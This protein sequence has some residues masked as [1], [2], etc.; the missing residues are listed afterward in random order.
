[1]KLRVDLSGPKGVRERYKGYLMRSRAEVVVAKRLD[2]E[3]VEWKYE[4]RVVNVG[5]WKFRIWYCPDFWVKGVGIIEVKGPAPTDMERWK[6]H[7]TAMLM[8]VDVYLV[9]DLGNRCLKFE[10]ISGKEV[11]IGGL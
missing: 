11:S 6:C 8:R 4:W 2:A 10:A 1:M 9:W 5:N 3:G 7:R